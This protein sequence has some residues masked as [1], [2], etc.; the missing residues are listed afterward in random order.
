MLQELQRTSLES[1]VPKHRVL[2]MQLQEF[3]R[4]EY[5]KIN[6]KPAKTVLLQ[7]QVFPGYP[8]DLQQPITTLLTQC[9]GLSILE[10]NIYE[11]RFQNVEYLNKMGANIRIDDKSLLIEGP[12]KLIGKEVKAT[13]LRAGA[14]L[15]L[16][17][18]IADGTTTI[19]DVK[20]IL[21]GY[22]N[23]IEK[24]SSLGAKISL[25]EE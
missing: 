5:Y 11:N 7:T 12:T 4:R 17:G 15:V 10:E 1:E 9:N 8:T 2:I 3:H 18:L 22:E 13:D 6:V 25:I 24:L 20:H 14:C 23:I 16:A 19:T 21:R